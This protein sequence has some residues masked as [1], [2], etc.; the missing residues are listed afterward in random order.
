MFKSFLK[1]ALRNLMKNKTFSLINIFG[2][3]IGLTCFVLIS[4]FIFDELS[5]DHYAANAKDIYRVNLSTIGNGDVA[6]YP[7]VDFG[8]GE[9]MKTAFP[10]IKYFSRLA[11]TADFVKYEDKQFKESKLAFVDSNFLQMFSIPLLEGNDKAALVQPNSVVISKALA[12]KYF[13]DA[14]PVGKPLIIGLRNTL[15]NVTGVFDKI[16]GNSHFHFDAFLSLATRN[17]T[18]PTWSNIGAFTYLLLDKNAD[19]KQLQ[20]KFPQLVAKHVVPEIQ[21]DMGVSL[22]EAQKSVN[23]F[24]FSLQ[25]L[26]GIHLRSQTKYEIEPGGDIQYVYIFSIIAGCSGCA[27]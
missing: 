13:G 17:I 3:T 26:T 22:A 20:A 27:F 9:G 15:Y 10:E 2:L 12:K 8:V 18:R 7:N 24:I 4:I 1:T 16:P 21:R 14:D 6:V 23:T 25:P 5:Y 11:P 19:I